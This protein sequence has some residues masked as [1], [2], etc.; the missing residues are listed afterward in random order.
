[1]DIPLN[2]YIDGA[3]K[4]SKS[5]KVVPMR[6]ISEDKE[7]D[8]EDEKDGEDSTEIRADGDHMHVVK[9]FAKRQKILSFLIL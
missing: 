5:H 6:A 1:M 8:E 9:Q 4:G 3:E 7:E 2:I